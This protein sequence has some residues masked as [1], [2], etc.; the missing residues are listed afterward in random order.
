MLSFVSRAL[1]WVCEAGVPNASVRLWNGR[2]TVGFFV[3]VTGGGF[4]GV[5]EE[6]VVIG[7]GEGETGFDG[8]ELS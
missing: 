8:G 5:S 2:G 6:I 7:D 3:G 1:R 4:D